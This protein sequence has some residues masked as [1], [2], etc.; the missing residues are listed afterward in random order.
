M[1]IKTDSGSYPENP[2]VLQLPPKGGKYI[3][4]LAGIDVMRFTDESDGNGGSFSTTY[5]VWD[6]LNANNTRIWLFEQG[7]GYHVGNLNPETLERVGSLEEVVPAR[8]S[9]V[10]YETACWS[11]DPDMIFLA[12]DCQIWAYKPSSKT[13]QT[14]ADLRS[15]FPTN[16]R[17]NQLYVSRDDNRFAAV[18]RSGSSGPGDYGVMVYE[19]SSKSIKLNISFTD[20]NGITMDKSGKFVLLVRNDPEGQVKQRIY[21]VDTGAVEVLVADLC[22]QC[23]FREG[24]AIHIAPETLDYHQFSRS[25]APDYCIGHN[26]CGADFVVGGDHWRGAFTVREMSAPHSVAMAWQ[27]AKTGWINWHVSMLADNEHWA[28]VST[29]GGTQVVNDKGET[30]VLQD[31]PFVREILQIGVK[32]P[33]IGQ[34]RRLLHTRANWDLPARNYWA[35][36]RGT[37]SGDGRLVCYTSNNNGPSDSRTDVFVAK[38][39]PAPVAGETQPPEPPTIPPVEPV[40]PP[41]APVTPSVTITAP[42]NG[43][44]VSGKVTVTV[45][46]TDPNSVTEMYLM[47]DDRSLVMPLEAPY[48]LDT[49]KLS[50]GPHVLIVRA[51]QGNTPIDSKPPVDVIVKNVVEPPVVT[52]P[53]PEEYKIETFNGTEAGR[54]GLYKKMWPLGY[55][56]WS[57]TDPDTKGNKIKFRRY[58]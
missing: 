34:K 51:W 29:Y 1:A 21:N 15:S 31:G 55:A 48:T 25:G 42:A 13:Y 32:D 28:L 54:T 8:G 17:F 41:V 3:D 58:K 2:K 49:T 27:Y 37:I 10:D 26:D 30:V 14:V 22:N 4:D 20:I 18:I 12:V 47:V 11:N 6:A 50:D 52:P 40:E 35:T 24:D 9:F 33:F 45:S 5:S 23:K 7:G 36:P 39:E 53:V 57:E 19:A 43:A 16:A 46:V 38:I 44:T 56:A